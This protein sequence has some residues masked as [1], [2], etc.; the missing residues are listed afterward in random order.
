[1]SQQDEAA[2]AQQEQMMANA[3]K[4]VKTLQTPQGINILQPFDGNPVKLHSFIRSVENVIPFIDALENTPYH[5]VW[6]QAIRNK[7]VGDAD[8]VLEVYGTELKWETIKANL[9]A[10]YNDKRDSTTLTRELFMAHQISSIEDFYARVQHL[11]SLLV[12]HANIQITDSA[13][14]TDRIKTYND[15]ALQVFLAGLK[16]PIGGNIRARQPKT[17]KE[18]FDACI[19]EQNFLSKTGWVR[20]V[21][22]K[23]QKNTFI[24]P[25]KPNYAFPR[26]PFANRI[27]LPPRQPAFYPPNI[28]FR[29]HAYRPPNPNFQKPTPMEVDKSLISKRINYMNRPQPS[30]FSHFGNQQ[31]PRQFGNQSFVPRQ[32]FPAAYPRPFGN[33]AFPPQQF[34]QTQ[35]PKFLVEELT[36]LEHDP[37]YQFYP[38]CNQFYADYYHYYPPYDYSD[39][40]EAVGK[41]EIVESAESETQEESSHDEINFQMDSETNPET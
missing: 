14:R 37:H 23:H 33:P 17:L 20:D 18:A 16:E 27:P 31:P 25:E 1:M 12:N 35:P 2:I 34:R 39:T 26:M 13:I 41:P 28:P 40:Q 19:E 22:Q 32:P 6:L 21:P 38:E 7:I 8:T 30:R 29:N 11:L 9:I 10:H 5:S 4:I 3:E 24:L 36:N 15:N